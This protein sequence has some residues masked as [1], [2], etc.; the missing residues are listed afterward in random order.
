M[1]FR[2]LKLYILA[3][4]FVCLAALGGMQATAQA[5]PGSQNTLLPNYSYAPQVFTAIST[6][7]ATIN[8]GG[9]RSGL[10]TATGVALT[11]AT[12]QIQG[13]ADGGTT[14]INLPTAAYPTTAVPITTTAVSETTTA[15]TV[16]VVNLAG[17]TNL[18]FATTSGTFTATSLSLKLTAS[19]NAGYL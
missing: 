19:G 2:D 16:Y 13:S 6:T 9:L 18:R 4:L 17:F 1:R 11:T 12:W 14:W 5:Y 3:A 7:G 15:A 10:I 8:I